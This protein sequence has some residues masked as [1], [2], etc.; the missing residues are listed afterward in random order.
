MLCL[1]MCY[2]SLCS[3]YQTLIA[4]VFIQELLCFVSLYPFCLLGDSTSVHVV[5]ASSHKCW[6]I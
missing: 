3:L 4:D 1:V 5:V 6:Q 2:V